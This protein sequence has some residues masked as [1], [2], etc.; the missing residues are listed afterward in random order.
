MRFIF[1]PTVSSLLEFFGIG[2][3]LPKMNFLGQ[4]IGNIRRGWCICST[5][6]SI[7]ASR[8][9]ARVSFSAFPRIFHLMLLR[10]IEGTAYTSGQKLDNVEG[11]PIVLASGHLQ[12]ALPIFFYWAHFSPSCNRPIRSRTLL[13]DQSSQAQNSKGLSTLARYSHGGTNWYLV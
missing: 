12:L 8:P 11:S 1:D 10:F 5:V 9:V 3:M 4:I 6:V 2:K 7:L 13:N